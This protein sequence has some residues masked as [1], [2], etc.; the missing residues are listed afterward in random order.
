MSV[1]QQRLKDAFDVQQLLTR[2]MSHRLKNLL[3]VVQ[4]LMHMASRQSTTAIDLTTRIDATLQALSVAR[5]V[6][7]S[8][9]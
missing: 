7:T 5:T 6:A 4:G 3:A 2:E 8:C 1:D 9:L